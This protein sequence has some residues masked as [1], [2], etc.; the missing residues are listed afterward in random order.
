MIESCTACPSFLIPNKTS[1][2]SGI[3]AI[4]VRP[5]CPP[6]L[7]VTA[8]NHVVVYDERIKVESVAQVVYDLVL[9]FGED[10]EEAMVNR[11]FGLELLMAGIDDL[12]QQMC[13][14][15]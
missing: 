7:R 2:S 1:E 11:A 14:D 6:S 10:E 12:G 3:E 4:K 15:H 9:W 5:A 8:K 13:D